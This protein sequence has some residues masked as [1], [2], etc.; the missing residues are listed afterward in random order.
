MAASLA[1]E[2]RNP[3]H[4]IEGFAR[5]LA[6]D[7]DKDDPRRRFAANIVAAV[8]NLEQTV[9][10]M[11]IFARPCRLNLGPVRADEVLEDVAQM[12]EQEIRHRNLENVVLDVALPALAPALRAD[13]EQLKRALLNLGHNAL[14]A[15]AGGGRLGLAIL[16]P[17]SGQGPPPLARISVSDSGSGIDPHILGRLFEPFATTKPNGNGLGLAMAR[18]IVELHEG[19]LTF[20]SQPGR[21]TT[22]HLDIP[23][24]ADPKAAARANRDEAAASSTEP[25]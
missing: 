6:Q 5:L 7:L 8:E 21:G 11:L 15:M 13:R 25:E 16:F 1:H 9:S 12:L 18:K 2:V 20:E 14:D 10:G 3:L 23:A 22:F 17:L 24:C 4:A 19:R